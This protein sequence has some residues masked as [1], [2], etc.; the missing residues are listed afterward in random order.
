MTTSPADML[1]AL[2]SGVRPAGA[3]APATATT[4]EGAGFSDLLARVRAGQVSSG[5]ALTVGQGVDAALSSDQMSRLATATDA[6]EAAGVGRLLAVIDD[7]A[8]TIDVSSRTIERV[9]GWPS[10]GLMTD[11]DA[12]VMVPSDGDSALRGL[13]AS[14]GQAATG[15]V[16][17]QD[18]LSGLSGISNPSVVDLLARRD[19]ESTERAA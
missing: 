9:R 17:R 6:A 19:A 18:M 5:Q 8:V 10:A 13:F 12:A 11:I 7:Q 15:G 1:R 2:G 16:A 4:I 14:I 3:D